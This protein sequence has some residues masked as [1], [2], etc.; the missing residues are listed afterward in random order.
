ML[1]ASDLDHGRNAKINYRLQSASETFHVER[2][3]GA[4]VVSSTIDRESVSTYI[5][6]VICIILQYFYFCEAFN[7]NIQPSVSW[8]SEIGA[9]IETKLFPES[10]FIIIYHLDFQTCISS[11]LVDTF[12]ALCIYQL[13]PRHFKDKIYVVY[14]DRMYVMFRHEQGSPINPLYSGISI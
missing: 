6:T 4:L 1:F 9:E 2:D 14:M 11:R 8:T 7:F 12:T 5:L 3:T 13:L 10:H